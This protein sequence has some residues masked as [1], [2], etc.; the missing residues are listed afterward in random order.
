MISLPVETQ[1]QRKKTSNLAVAALPII[2][3]VVVVV[4]VVA[5]YATHLL[6]LL[7]TR[8]EQEAHDLAR[9]EERGTVFI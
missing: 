1:K 9:N 5:A 6:R 2:V 7:E 3:V 8:T 4:V